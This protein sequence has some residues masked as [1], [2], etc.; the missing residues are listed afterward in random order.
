[1][2]IAVQGGAVTGVVVLLTGLSAGLLAGLW[3]PGSVLAQVGAWGLITVLGF[4]IVVVAVIGLPV[5]ILLRFGIVTP[6]LAGTGIA[7]VW[8]LFGGNGALTATAVY[9]RA[10]SAI[11]WSPIYPIIYLIVGAAEY[12][13]RRSQHP[14]QE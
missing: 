3:E 1:M 10:L 5:T 11:V 2:K 4:L 12:G 8:L 7:V 14:L 6:V 9:G 13:L